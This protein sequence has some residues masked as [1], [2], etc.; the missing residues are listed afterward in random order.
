MKAI[1][2]TSPKPFP[3]ENTLHQN[4]VKTKDC[5]SIFLLQKAQNTVF[6]SAGKIEFEK[7]INLY[8]QLDENDSWSELEKK[9]MPKFKTTYFDLLFFNNKTV[10][11]PGRENPDNNK[12]W[13]WNVAQENTVYSELDSSKSVSQKMIF[14]ELFIIQDSTRQIQWKITDETRV[15][16]GFQCRRANAIIMDSVYVVAFYADDIVTPGGPES[17]SGLPGMILGVSL[18]HQ[19]VTWFATKVSALPVTAA[20]LKAPSRGKKV[21][22]ASLKL[23]LQDRMKEWGK[24]RQKNLEAVML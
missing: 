15:I 3:K 12:L 11:R 9:M 7:K 20:E 17:F 18:P 23:S 21:T 1:F 4:I 24:E 22:I 10:Y 5:S 19:H 13:G 2:S 14:E 8:A 16:A 6:L